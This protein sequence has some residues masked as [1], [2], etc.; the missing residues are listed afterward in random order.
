MGP[1]DPATGQLVGDTIEEQTAQAIRNVQAVLATH[2][3]GLD[4]V[5]KTT[6]HLADLTRDFAGFNSTYESSLTAPYPVRTTVGS[7][8][9]GFLVEIDVVAAIR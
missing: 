9:A 8:L 3:L 5:I 1:H 4:D 2:G 6:M 7:T